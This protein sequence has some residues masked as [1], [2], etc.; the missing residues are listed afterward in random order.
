MKV[1]GHFQLEL[2]IIFSRSICR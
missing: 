1:V 2:N